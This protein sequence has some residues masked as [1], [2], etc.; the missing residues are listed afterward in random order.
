MKSV[1]DKLI[2]DVSLVIHLGDLYSDF[3]ALKY[4]Y[5]NLRTYCVKGNCDYSAEAP[6]E[7]TFE[8]MGYNIFLAHGHLYSVKT[9]YLN[10]IAAAHARNA[11]VCLFGH[12]HIPD[13]FYS[14]KTLFLNPGSISYA[15]NT[16][17]PTYGIL[18]INNDN[19]EPSVTIKDNDGYKP[20][21]INIKQI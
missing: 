10:I 7:E 1:T 6:A 4:A 16:G 18:N 11:D 20:F 12:T 5:P 9:T 19:I 21:K 15:R 14:G 2:N 8:L 17:K 3:E 13:I